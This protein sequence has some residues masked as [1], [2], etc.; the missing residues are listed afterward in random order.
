MKGF[1]SNIYLF[2]GFLIW[3]MIILAESIHGTIRQLFLA[4][5][6]GDFPARRIAVFT[7]MILI[8]LVTWL[9]VN[10][11]AAPNVRSL[12]AIGLFWIILTAMFEF[13]LGFFVFGFSSERLFEDYDISRGG[14]MGFGLL[15]MFFAPFLA[16]KL[17]AK[18]H[19]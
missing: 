17:R 2:R 10:W 14:L 1:E 12:F 8:F 16:C 5:L 9:F 13:G 6:V 11:I 3:L 19:R 18:I 15:F 7:G 4:P